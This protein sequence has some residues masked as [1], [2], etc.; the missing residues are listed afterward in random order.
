MRTCWQL[1][2][3]RRGSPPLG[4]AA[5]AVTHPRQRATVSSVSDLATGREG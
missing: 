5:T 4:S 3:N 1:V 2:S